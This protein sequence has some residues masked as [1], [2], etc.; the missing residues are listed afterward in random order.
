MEKWKRDRTK[1]ASCPPFGLTT[2]THSVVHKRSQVLVRSSQAALVPTRWSTAG[3]SYADLSGRSALLGY[4]RP[5]RRQF[6]GRSIGEAS[7]TYITMAADTYS[8]DVQRKTGVPIVSAAK[9]LAFA[10][11]SSPNTQSPRLHRAAHLARGRTGSPLDAAGCRPD[12]EDPGL[13]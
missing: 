6:V 4:P 11:C 2:K 1:T 3:A 13:A 10:A 8:P 9:L 12:A 5:S 7:S